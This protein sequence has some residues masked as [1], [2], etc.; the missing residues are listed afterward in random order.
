MDVVGPLAIAAEANIN[1]LYDVPDR[2]RRLDELA[3][4]MEANGVTF[5]TL[6]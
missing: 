5:G 3:K 6:G 2:P 4:P 1:G